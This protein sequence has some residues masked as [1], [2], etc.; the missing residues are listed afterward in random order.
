MQVNKKAILALALLFFVAGCGPKPTTEI[1]FWNGIPVMPGAVEIKE[2]D[3]LKE[4]QVYQYIV[5]AD[6]ESAEKF[7]RDEL[8]KQGWEILGASKPNVN[9]IP[10]TVMWVA[11]G[12]HT[13]QIEVYLK[14][15]V[16]H[17]ALMLY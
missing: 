7:Y 3:S 17:V 2:R 13:G 6:L 1:T 14:G 10:A 8:K 4:Y 11:K 15:D 5:N 16:T 12:G 9:N